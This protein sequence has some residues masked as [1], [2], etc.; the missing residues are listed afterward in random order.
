MQFCETDDSEALFRIRGETTVRCRARRASDDAIFLVAK[1]GDYVL[2]RQ[3]GNA[4]FD[5]ELRSS[6]VRSDPCTG[7][8][9]ELYSLRV[10]NCTV[11]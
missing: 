1:D 11:V 2:R 10:T 7:T 8:A 3:G 9:A 4:F 6:L 5:P